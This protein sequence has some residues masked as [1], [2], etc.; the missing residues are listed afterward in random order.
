M[1]P[2]CLAMLGAALAAAAIAAGC[3]MPASQV[4]IE[5]P[6][7]PVLARGVT[8]AAA[9]QAVV[10]GRSSKADV[11]RALGAATVVHF[12]SGYEVW[13]YQTQEDANAQRE[14]SELVILFAPSGVVKKTRVRVGGPV[15]AQP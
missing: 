3:A 6:P 8:P 7:A 15:R 14:P 1:R 12:D 2:A 9:A 11:A 13:V 5:K 4:A 10:A